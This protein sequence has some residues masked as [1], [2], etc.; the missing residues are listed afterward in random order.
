MQR[1]GRFDEKGAGA[2]DMGLRDCHL[3]G[4]DLGNGRLKAEQIEALLAFAYWDS[5][6]DTVL[7]G[8]PLTRK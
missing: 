3:K 7:S 2:V 5:A 6:Q 1:A 8:G 4:W